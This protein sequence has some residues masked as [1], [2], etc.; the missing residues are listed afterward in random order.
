LRWRTLLWWLAFAL[1]TVAVFLHYSPHLS[2][3]TP[4][5][6]NAGLALLTLGLLV[7]GS[8]N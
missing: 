5:L 7:H 6:I 8:T 2:R 1:F 3:H 4:T